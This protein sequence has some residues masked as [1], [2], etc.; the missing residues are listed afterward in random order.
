MFV[1]EQIQ[2]Q[3]LPKWKQQ[4][5]DSPEEARQYRRYQDGTN[6][7]RQRSR[8]NDY[9]SREPISAKKLLQLEEMRAKEKRAFGLGDTVTIQVAAGWTTEAQIVG[10]FV[11]GGSWMYETDCGYKRSVSQAELLTIN[12]RT[13]SQLIDDMRA[14][15][16]ECEQVLALKRGSRRRDLRR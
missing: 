14:L 5:F 15:V 6:G 2:K 8:H 3:R 16:M 10:A 12:T 11:S 9:E 4:G 13:E 7:R 1:E